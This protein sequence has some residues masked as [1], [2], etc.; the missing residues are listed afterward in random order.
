MKRWSAIAAGMLVI[1]F[2]SFHF[3]PE[4][5]GQATAGWTTLFDGSSL[6][7]WNTIGD[8]DWK[9]ADGI[10]QADK[11]TG[12]L[13]S[14]ASYGDFQIHVEF[15]DTGDTNSGVFLRCS[16]P[17]QVSPANAYEVNIWDSRTVDN[18]RTGAIVD[19]AKPT[20][21]VN[22]VDKWNTYEITAQGTHLV[23]TLN[24][25]RTVDVNDSKYARGPIAL[26]YAAVANGAGVIKFRK[27]QIK[28][29]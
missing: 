16:K 1:A 15:W 6:D 4:A 12:F 27:V 22:T 11:G 8:A 17:E 25:T 5:H 14:K 2:L 23:V 19:L 7:S 20:A 26:Q 18:Y 28:P 3:N 9:L 13:V 29:L 10:V 24:G 21:V